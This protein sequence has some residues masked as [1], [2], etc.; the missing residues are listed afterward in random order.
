MAYSKSLFDPTKR[1]LIKKVTAYSIALGTQIPYGKYFPLSLA[2]VALAKPPGLAA[3]KSQGLTVL[4]ERPLNIE[5]P[6]HLLDDDITPAERLFV[7]NNGIPPLIAPAEL[8]NWQ[9]RI[10]GR[11]LQELSFSIDALKN[12]FEQVTLQLPIECG[13]N[14]RKFFSPSVS[15]NQW[16]FGAIGCPKW[17]GI[18][19]RDVLNAAGLDESA[20]HTAHY[21]ADTHLSGDPTKVPISR[22]IPIEKALEKHTIIAWSINDNPIPR[23]HGFPLRLV[24]PGWPGSC[25]HKW[26]NRI[27][28]RDKIHDGP[29]MMGYSYRIPTY[30]VAPGTD[31]PEEDMAI[32]TEMPVKSMITHPETGHKQKTRVF[33]EVRGSAWAG[34]TAIDKVEISID[35]GASWRPV[36]LAP[37]SNKY[38]WRRWKASLALPTIGYYE[39]WARATDTSGMSQPANPPGW[40]PRGYL[41][42]MQHRIA[43]FSV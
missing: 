40:N 43:I 24:V 1:A 38:A 11:V 3:N 41:N 4:S 15:G 5:T 19:L 26:L 25:S 30:P 18:R 22:G 10:E 12:Q 16:S 20:K 36:E 8:H 13:G 17:T 33:F 34:E 23:D 27:V 21:G 7:R 37:A 14:G 42:N 31:V 2:P 39:I 6:P 28:I 29:K 35:F 32:I 9:L